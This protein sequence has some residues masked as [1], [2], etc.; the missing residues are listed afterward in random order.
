M[1][2]YDLPDPKCRHKRKGRVTAGSAEPGH[3]HAAT[4]VC[5]RPACIEDAK[6]WARAST[7]QEPEYIPDAPVDLMAALEAS[8][9]RASGTVES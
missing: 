7:H 9:I 5:D 6:E 4:S 8:L 1:S 2:R 3:A